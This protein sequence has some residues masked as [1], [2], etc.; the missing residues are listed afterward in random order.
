MRSY[1]ILF[2]SVVLSINTWTS[3]SQNAT[4]SA[5]QAGIKADLEYITINLNND[6]TL[7]R[8]NGI[9]TTNDIGK[10]IA[11][12]K[13]HH[14]GAERGAEDVIPYTMPGRL[15]TA[16]AV[17]TEVSEEGIATIEVI[18]GDGTVHGTILNKTGTKEAYY[19][20]NNYSLLQ[21]AI[22]YCYASNFDV[23]SFDL[24]GIIGVNPYYKDDYF[25][26]PTF[27]FNTSKNTLLFRSDVGSLTLLNDNNSRIKLC[28][29]TTDTA[30]PSH[31]FSSTIGNGDI[32]IEVP[33]VPADLMTTAFTI[34]TGFFLSHSYYDISSGNSVRKVTIKNQN[35]NKETDANNHDAFWVG[36]YFNSNGGVNSE[37]PNN[38]Q[39]QE[40][41]FENS[42]FRVKHCG[43]SVFSN[44][45]PTNVE[46]YNNV[47][48]LKIDHYDNENG[49]SDMETNDNTLDNALNKPGKWYFNLSDF[50]FDGEFLSTVSEEIDFS[51][52]DYFGEGNTS[53][54]DHTFY[55][56][57]GMIFV[58]D[59]TWSGNS[60]HKIKLNQVSSEYITHEVPN[61]LVVYFSRTFYGHPHYSHANVSFHLNNVTSTNGIWRY[62]GGA[63][64][65]TGQTLYNKIENSTISSNPEIPGGFWFLKPINDGT[66]LIIK[67]SNIRNH[68]ITACIIDMENSILYGNNI[69][70]N[71]L[72]MIGSNNEIRVSGEVKEM[73][74]FTMNG[75]KYGSLLDFTHKD[76]TKT[77]L[78]TLNNVEFL[79]SDPQPNGIIP[80]GNL[81]MLKKGELHVNDAVASNEVSLKTNFNYFD[82]Q[83]KV[84]F[85]NVSLTGN[86]PTYPSWF[87]QGF[88]EL[89][90]EFTNFRFNN[91]NHKHLPRATFDKDHK[92]NGMFPV[93]NE[94][95][96]RGSIFTSRVFD[97]G[98]SMR[99]DDFNMIELNTLISNSF[100][101][102]NEAASIV[103]AT[104][105]EAL[106][107]SHTY[108]TYTH[109]ANNAYVTGQITIEI[110]Q[111][112]VLN[113]YYVQS[114]TGY[115]KRTNTTQTNLVVK[116]V[117]REVGEIITFEF[118][119][120]N[121]RLIEVASTVQDHYT[122]DSLP[123]RFG[124]K[125][126]ILISAIEPGKYFKYIIEHEKA[127][128]N[129]FTIDSDS[130]INID[131]AT[132]L[133]TGLYLSI[134]QELSDGTEWDDFEFELITDTGESVL[135]KT[136]ETIA[137][138]T[139]NPNYL[140]NWWNF[141]G[142][143]NNSDVECYIENRTGQIFFYGLMPF[144]LREVNNF[145]VISG[146]VV[147][148]HYWE[149]HFTNSSERE[150]L[151]AF[152]YASGGPSWNITWNTSEPMN[153]WYGVTLNA[154]GY[155]EK[156][157]LPNNNLTGKVPANLGVLT[158]LKHL[159][160]SNNDLSGTIPEDIG[161]MTSL[162]YLYFDN[163]NLTGEI[164]SSL[165]NL[166]SLIVLNGSNNNFF[167]CFPAE[168][169]SLCEGVTVDFTGNPLL[170]SGGDFAAFCSSD[171]GSCE[172]LSD[173]DITDVAL[174]SK[175]FNLYPNPNYGNFY[176]KTDNVVE[177]LRVEIY[178]LL[179][180]LVYTSSH[181][182]VNEVNVKLNVKTGVYLVKII[183]PR[184]KIT[185][186]TIIQ[187]NKKNI[188]NVNNMNRNYF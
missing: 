77:V 161:N 70:T 9:F 39:Y 141:K 65:S 24:N 151:E 13:G 104:F 134:L 113:P 124:V 82:S 29:E 26:N 118:D 139:A 25:D 90:I 123:N 155:V 45:G 69:E 8:I 185:K 83:S 157:V 56:F 60:A 149:V 48:I 169:N 5:S 6:N 119:P 85:N 140:K 167:G 7:T 46:N 109:I 121:A 144:T 152:Y 127:D 133:N 177:K 131:E 150:A 136:S 91:Y 31:L 162:E 72:H 49:R 93:S 58:R 20:T 117:D 95:N 54:S 165:G 145:K 30:Y 148:T 44:Y 164:P 156:L 38:I 125:D 50:T 163:N 37:D 3:S 130:I 184:S 159:A 41:N 171:E 116:S 120:R 19:Y 187:S 96:E 88:N 27:P 172:T 147:T 143:Y 186:K 87:Y 175:E 176:L 73:E 15:V 74:S 12:K 81:P 110:G 94:S 101:I 57:D 98:Y 99:R 59:M 178:D 97:H 182:Y 107:T 183:L 33:C 174:G 128:G 170:P 80:P 18:N 35:F 115:T 138:V 66:N 21:K 16:T 17:I 92:Y 11:I 142:E 181:S 160:L 122:N 100:L 2:L 61:K 146:H 23:F 51:F 36:A 84:F 129:E 28:T 64:A 52:Y 89:D 68:Q 62:Q 42:L 75:G 103:N 76:S 154:N 55:I 112:G 180:K 126:E 4:H 135:F 43:V 71:T 166:T 78:L 137:G 22:D 158:H 179:G 40:H 47:E 108:S 114:N 153:T 34:D 1:F 63:H 32:T 79:N 173:D 67:N 106:G 105:D 102:E 10:F 188:Y 168:L 86:S 132:Q 14:N 111:G 53:Y